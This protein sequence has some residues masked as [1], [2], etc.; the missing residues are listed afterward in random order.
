ME[1][2]YFGWYS[3]NSCSDPKH[4]QNG[5]SFEVNELEFTIRKRNIS[6]TRYPSTSAHNFCY[7]LNILQQILWWKSNW[8]LDCHFFHVY[9]WMVNSNWNLLH[10]LDNGVKCTTSQIRND[11]LSKL[12]RTFQCRLHF[13]AQF[14]S[15][16]KW[17]KNFLLIIRRRWECFIKLLE[18]SVNLTY[19]KWHSKSI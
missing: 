18:P 2:F 14:R 13:K 3:N 17:E 15:G 6:S 7:S 4:F 9:N 11:Y 19:K 8:F 1:C 16:R 10:L 5:D 12:A